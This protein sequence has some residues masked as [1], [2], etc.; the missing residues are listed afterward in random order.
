MIQISGVFP[1]MAIKGNMMPW[2]SEVGIGAL[3]PWADYLWLVTY[4]AHKSGTGGGTGLFY[5]NDQMQIKKHPASVTGTFANRLVHNESNQLFIGPHAIDVNGNVRNI[6]ALIEQ[7]IRLAATCRH[8]TDP[9]NKVYFLGME[10][11][12]LEVDVHSLEATTLFD[13][14]KELDME[15]PIRAHF[16]DAYCAHGLVVVANNTYYGGDFERGYSNGRL[17][18]WDGERWTVLE[19]TQFNTTGGRLAGDMGNAIYCVGQDRASALLKLYLPETGW[20][21]YRLPKATHTQDHAWTTEWPRLREIESERWMLNA[22]GMFYELPAMTYTNRLWGVRPVCSHLR[23]IADYCS[24]NGLLVMAGDQTTPINDSNAYVGQPLSNL[25]FGKSDDL[26]SWGEPKGWGGPWWETEV[27][28]GEPSDPYLFYGFKHKCLHISIENAH[29][30]VKVDIELDF[31]GDGKFQRYK[32]LIV[33]AHGLSEELPAGLAAHWLRLVP[34]SDCT[35]T[36][37]LFY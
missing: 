25:W 19:K 15:P 34:H 21:N 28:A 32:T 14:T 11:E 10:G 22:S 16:K 8:L 31:R 6:P 24:W 23:I 37:Q 4:L 17:A 12:F 2:R 3:M 20:Q 29:A 5:I 30:A 7:D 18:Q 13:L 9:A 26:W 1:S 35:A 36:A 33:D 27:K